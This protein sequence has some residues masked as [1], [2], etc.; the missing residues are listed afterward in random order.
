MNVDAID[1]DKVVNEWR[2]K[3]DG[4]MLTKKIPALG[5][6]RRKQRCSMGKGSEQ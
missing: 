6:S 3:L 5:A 2:F 1:L 4:S